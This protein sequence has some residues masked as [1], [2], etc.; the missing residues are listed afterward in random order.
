M[1]RLNDEKKSKRIA[2]ALSEEIDVLGQENEEQ[3]AKWVIE[4][5]NEIEKKKESQYNDALTFFSEKNKRFA[6][7]YEAL[8]R[9]LHYLL[10][11]YVDWAGYEF[12]KE[13]TFSSRGVGVMI[14]DPDGDVYARGF[15]PNGDPKYD[16]HAIKVLIWQTE[17]VVEEYAKKQSPISGSD[18][19]GT[20]IIKG[21]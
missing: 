12:E 20:A 3:A 11:H 9:Q 18:L 15:K 21:D 6:T 17:N 5:G 13:S 7:Y 8:A 4:K 2:A 1:S 14:K 10:Y 19:G 16:L